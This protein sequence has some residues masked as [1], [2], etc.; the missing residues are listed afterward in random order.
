MDQDAWRLLHANAI[1]ERKSGMNSDER[2]VV[3]EACTA[4]LSPCALQLG[5]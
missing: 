2:F 3:C 4:R 1:T 5:V